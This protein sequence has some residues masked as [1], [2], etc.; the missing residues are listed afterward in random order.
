M[1]K[2]KFNKKQ[3]YGGPSKHARA[4]LSPYSIRNL[5]LSSPALS[6]YYHF[7]VRQ[8]EKRERKKKENF[9]ERASRITMAFSLA[10]NYLCFSAYISAEIRKNDARDFGARVYI[11]I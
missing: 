6:G 8:V 10:M 11:Y 4:R 5:S 3:I 1:K 7:F 9:P 2:S